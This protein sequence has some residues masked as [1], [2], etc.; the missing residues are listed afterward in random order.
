MV[1]HRR[2]LGVPLMPQLSDAPVA[3][4]LR[5]EGD[6]TNQSRMLTKSYSLHPN[7]PSN[8]LRPTTIFSFGITS[9]TRKI[10]CFP[11]RLVSPQIASL[12]PHI[13]SYRL[14]GEA[15]T[16]GRTRSKNRQGVLCYQ[17]CQNAL[18]RGSRNTK[19]LHADFG[20][21]PTGGPDLVDDGV[22]RREGRGGFGSCRRQR[23]S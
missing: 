3:F 22:F 1:F 8:S 2:S 12:P 7:T 21:D 9:R 6:S 11:Y 15:V 4:I 13:A 19:S 16:G 20:G 5:L 18:R 10:Y 14:I 17:F 23:S